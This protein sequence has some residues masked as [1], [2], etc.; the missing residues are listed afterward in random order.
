MAGD[1]LNVNL[2]LINILETKLLALLILGL[3]IFIWF[4][5]F[6]VDYLIFKDRFEKILDLN[7][8]INNEAK[9][10]IKLSLELSKS[11]KDIINFNN[12]LLMS[13]EHLFDKN[14]AL[15]FKILK[16]EK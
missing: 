9:N 2:L 6:F 15:R 8:R 13:I 12:R 4:V 16:D 14:D 5:V 7:T 10:V 1:I 11:A 3:S